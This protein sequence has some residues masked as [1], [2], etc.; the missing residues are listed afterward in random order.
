MYKG[1]W[2][3]D[4]WLDVAHIP[5]GGRPSREARGAEAHEGE[6]FNGQVR[7]TRYTKREDIAIEHYHVA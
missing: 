2:K 3:E 1:E 7:T 6:P 4:R 5:G